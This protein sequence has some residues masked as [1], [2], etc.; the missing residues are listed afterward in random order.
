MKR[1]LISLTL[2]VCALSAMAQVDTPKWK[3]APSFYS[4][5]LGYTRAQ[6]EFKSN[7][8]DIGATLTWKYIYFGA[9]FGIGKEDGIKELAAN[10]KVGGAMPFKLKNEGCIVV[11]PYVAFGSMDYKYSG[12]TS[13]DFNVGPGLKATYILPSKL[14]IGAYF[15]NIWST[16]YNSA[17]TQNMTFGISFGRAF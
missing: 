10:I 2:L 11:S 9:T 6:Y 8:V 17:N 16:D 3:N 15:Q 14:A 7:L 5:E 13:S 1:L 12:S 4:V